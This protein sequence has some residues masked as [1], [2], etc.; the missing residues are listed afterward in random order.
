MTDWREIESRVFM[1]TGRRMP[2]VV[3]KGEGTRVWD[4]AGKSYLDFFGGPAVH[5]LG[6]CHPVMVKA[7]EE[8]AR[9]LIHVSNA[10]Y[11]VPQL[12]LA[13]LLLDNSVFDR[14]YFT[15]SGAEANEAAIKLAHKW[16]REHKNG[17]Y[18]IIAMTD[19]F[20]GRTLAAVTATGTPRYHEP[21]GPL[22]P[23]FVHVPFNDIEALQNATTPKTAAILV[24]PIQ[25]EGGVNVPNPSYF[26]A[27]RRWCD[28]NNILLMVD[29][30]QTGM[31][32]TGP[33]FAYQGM[34]FEPDVMT[35]A[36]GLGGGVPIG[37]ILAKESC[38]VFTPGDHGS[39][40]GGNP[41]M[42]AV[43]LAVT[44]YMIETDMP[45]RVEKIGAYLRS[46]LE[47]MAEKLPAVVG[48]RGK[49]LLLAI[50]LNADISEKVVL[51]CLANGLIV[52]NV[53]PNAVRLAPP[54]T[55]TEAECDEAVEIIEKAVA[56]AA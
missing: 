32:R 38:S 9:T 4:D 35:L 14:V 49:G 8:Q 46:K 33:L 10:V 21:F 15:N 30:V 25:G 12:K 50:A 39:T 34:D 27:M 31:C 11:S 37:A 1:T 52:N 19:G 28:E 26:P 44:K 22:P 17:A 40:Y 16:G 2:V 3:V 47:A 36:K 7:I 51:D 45:A 48:V 20:H 56:R 6:H 55:V 42:T 54:L 18:E 41:L 29:E 24:E 43:A 23:G 5:A 13:Q 53:R